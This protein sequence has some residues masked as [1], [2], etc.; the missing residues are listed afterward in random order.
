MKL[1]THEWMA[2]ELENKKLRDGLRPKFWAEIG[3][4][5]AKNSKDVDIPPS[6][7]SVMLAQLSETM[8]SGKE[9]DIDLH[10]ITKHAL[11]EAGNLGLG[12]FSHGGPSLAIDMNLIAP[13]AL[14]SFFLEEE[15]TAYEQSRFGVDD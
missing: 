7:R 13:R 1:L 12:S 11:A 9:K 3:I 2:A 6:A 8:L 15:T 4:T 14:R 10:S 5:P